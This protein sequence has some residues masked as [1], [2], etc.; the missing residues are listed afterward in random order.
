[1]RDAV[2][3]SALS[4][5][6]RIGI[7][8]DT[9]GDM[10][11]MLST[12]RTMHGRGIRT[13]VVLGDFGFIWPGRNWDN[14]LDK[15]SR[16]LRDTA[17]TLFFVDGNHEDFTRLYTFP[18]A[19]DG[20][21][22]VRP[23]I[24]HIP[25]GWRTTLMSGRALAALGGANSIDAAERRAGTSWWREESITE[26]DLALLGDRRADVLIGHDAP[27]DVP[28][29]DSWLKES[30]ARWSTSGLEYAD[31]GRAMFHRGFMQVRPALYLG[32]H[33][34]HH[35]DE[36]IDYD[37]DNRFTSRVVLLDMNGAEQ[38]HNLAILDAETLEI[39][40]LI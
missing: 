31:A 9:H 40:Y 25:R 17:Q 39:E 2:G 26:T 19:D 32:G 18:V 21:R 4:A 38:A 30:S 7:V 10:G 20:L 24:A 37:E 15:L 1:M 14:D 5:A 22:W 36:F 35:V 11:F 27:L 29:L 3:P 28:Q 23:N 33:Y 12:F 34:H 16:R 6:L 8:G 13:L